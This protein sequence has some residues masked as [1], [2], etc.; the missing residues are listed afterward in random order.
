MEI[1]RP[2][3]IPP[4][5]NYETWQKV[6]TAHDHIGLWYMYIHQVQKLWQMGNIAVILCGS[7]VPLLFLTLQLTV[8]WMTISSSSSL[9]YYLESL[10]SETYLFSQ[11]DA[12]KNLFYDSCKIKSLQTT[13]LNLTAKQ[14]VRG[15][16]GNITIDILE[17]ASW[18]DEDQ[19]MEL[20]MCQQDN[21]ETRRWALRDDGFVCIIN[22]GLGC[23]YLHRWVIG[24][25]KDRVRKGFGNL[26]FETLCYLKS[27]LNVTVCIKCQLKMNFLSKW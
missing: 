21:K 24:L 7:M 27:N 13:K 23:Y 16:P 14:P 2:I 26:T 25:V 5:Q 1:Q 18:V 12:N 3:F 9:K 11:K 15:E 4:H 20:R 22:N 19:Q 17:G 10:F 8:L 6:M